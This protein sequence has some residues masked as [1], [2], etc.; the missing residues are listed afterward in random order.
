MPRLKGWP[1]DPD[2]ARLLA[3]TDLDT[4][5]A[6]LLMADAGCRLR[7]ALDFDVRS[8]TAHSQLRIFSTKSRSWRTVPLTRRLWSAIADVVP[9]LLRPWYDLRA[10]PLPAG[11]SRQPLKHI[12]PRLLQ[13]R[14][15]AAAAAAL[16]HLTSPHRLRHSYASRLAAEGV[17]IHV[18]SALLGHKS[19]TVTLLYIHGTGD[20]YANAAQALDRRA[21]KAT[22][23]L[24]RSPR[25]RG[26]I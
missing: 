19:L 9:E 20:D 10:L 16:P 2:I 14:I 6:I 13:R 26:T 12:Y 18:I 4:R 5:L 7:E 22:K 17:P 11:L 24:P 3:A 21:R 23:R 15:H 8:L 1:D 25:P